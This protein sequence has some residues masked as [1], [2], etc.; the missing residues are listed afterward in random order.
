MDPLVSSACLEAAPEIFNRRDGNNIKVRTAVYLELR[1]L[2]C[3]GMKLRWSPLLVEL[4]FKCTVGCATL[5]AAKNF[6][7]L[8]ALLSVEETPGPGDHF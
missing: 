6:S 8:R 7:R 5:S 2:G 4:P 1:L 3:Y